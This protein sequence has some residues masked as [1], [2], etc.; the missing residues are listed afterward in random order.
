MVTVKQTNVI[1]IIETHEDLVH[2][3]I[4]SQFLK[5]LEAKLCHL[6]VVEKFTGLFRWGRKRLCW[7]FN[8]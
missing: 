1:D 5:A 8:N 6:S 3:G 2:L 7:K 4:Y